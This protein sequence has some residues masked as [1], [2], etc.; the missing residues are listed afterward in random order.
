[1]NNFK[2][3][4]VDA[5]ALIKTIEAEV[6]KLDAQLI[7]TSSKLSKMM[8]GGGKNVTNQI[9]LLTSQV[10]KLN[11]AYV[12]QQSQLTK[13][14]TAKT[15]LSVATSKVATS[16]TRENSSIQKN[17]ELN[18]KNQNAIEGSTRAEIRREKA[19][20]RAFDRQEH[21][22]RS[23]VKLT[24]QH[25]KAKQVLQDSIVTNGKNNRETRRAQK[26]YDKLTR[27]VNKA[28][29]ATKRFSAR[30]LNSVSAGFRNLLG[31]F[32]IVGGI[33]IFS[34]IVKNVFEL[35]KT[36]D[37]LGFALERVAGDSLAAADSQ[38]FLVSLTE[39]FGVELVSTTNRWIKFLAAAKQ[40]GIT[41]KDTEDIFRTMAK[42]SGVL[43][44]KTDELTGIYLA[45]EQ[46]ISKGKVT[47][48]ELRRQ[49]GER[50]PGAMGIM[51]TAVGVTVSKLD[52][53]LKK[54]EVL[55]AEVL[56]KFAKAVEL[57]Y[58]L[59][60]VERVTTLVA[61]QNRLTTSWQLFIKN[62]TAD[63]SKVK[64]VFGF[65][66]TVLKE[67][68]GYMDDLL[69]GD[70]Q[71]LQKAITF[72]TSDLENEMNQDAEANFSMQSPIPGEGIVMRGAELKRQRDLQY[73]EVTLA[74]KDQV[75]VEEEKYAAILKLLQDHNEEVDAFKK[76]TAED[77]IL[78]AK[79]EFLEQTRIYEEFLEKKK[80]KEAAYEKTEP[81]FL[82][83]RSY[84]GKIKDQK[85]SIKEAFGEEATFNGF[86]M[87]SEEA[88]EK[89]YDTVEN[90]LA[91][92]TSKWTVFKKLTEESKVSVPKDKEED[93][94]NTTIKI[95]KEAKAR[96]ELE[97]MR[98]ELK[99]KRLNEFAAKEDIALDHR[100]ESNQSA[101]ET[102]MKLI[103]LIRDY[104]VQDLKHRNKD[105]E[106]NSAQEQV[107]L[108]EA[109]NAK[110]EISKK[111][112]DEE[113]DITT[114]YLEVEKEDSKV[115]LEE[116][117]AIRKRKITARRNELK[118]AGKNEK[119]IE[120][121]LVKYK[122]E[123]YEADMKTW[124]G[125]EIL[126]LEMLK[127]F[128]NPSQKKLLQAAID[129]MNDILSKLGIDSDI[130]KNMKTVKELAIELFQELDALGSAL[131]DNKAQ[132]V[133]DEI[134]MNSDKYA[135]IL[136]DEN[137]TEQQR[138]AIEAER[139][140]KEAELEKKKRVIERRKAVFEKAT[141]TA[142][143]IVNTARAISRVSYNPALVALTAA[144]GAAQL[145]VIAATPIPKYAKGKG[146]YDNYEGAAIWGEKR[147]E[148]KIG[149]D[150]SME[151]SPNKIG[152]HLTHVKK[153]DVI[154]PN[155]SQFFASLNDD[156]IS[157]GAYNLGA[158]NNMR[159]AMANG[160][161]SSRQIVDA[162]NKQKT[163]VKINQTLNIGDDL[164]FLS[165]MNNTL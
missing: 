25:K 18:S 14:S 33:S 85:N 3:A 68:V 70:S 37:G 157:R 91:K 136:D 40:S 87:D 21:L 106:E 12:K 163:S 156:E 100:Q 63:E 107:I 113:K 149:K 134:Q 11:I 111:Y 32:G 121:E 143:T 65:I 133:D 79:T 110:L 72:T 15:N 145:G 152:N 44:L 140:R 71:S 9:K 48:E 115:R 147:Q 90:N 67:A 4:Q 117:E 139:D 155:A 17:V 64:E 83:F 23:F 39:D 101:A 80:I 45:L 29:I 114:S 151:V 154:H 122:K 77:G 104:K 144:I 109:V 66:L 118:E 59:D 19:L 119:E 28:T 75:I 54:G 51:A 141:A 89:V 49:L 76:K 124:L 97:K 131:F 20:K 158:Q 69:G 30:G 50:L 130:K 86:V 13:L 148:V 88:F 78:S 1:M 31:V 102:E 22:S 46:M 128:A 42:V 142:M 8:S 47:T 164:K 150:G 55:S 36:F 61:E 84:A 35:T 34:N 125:F 137:L 92:A 53:M 94:K 103:D 27:K 52:E 161:S 57:A 108:Q 24:A 73:I 153:D 123:L 38:R 159:R 82:K 99:I 7:N 60:S 16:Q 105:L 126:K 138:S 160:Q 162:I 146:D 2:K 127:A 62:I 5:I 129:E 116:L 26:E 95:D 135:K 96:F 58:S 165:R 10:E 43:G 112:A 81:G 41:L 98:L 74:A 93:G 6:S 56:P 120:D 132:Q